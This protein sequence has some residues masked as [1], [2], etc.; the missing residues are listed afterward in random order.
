MESEEG[1]GTTMFFTIKKKALQRSVTI[2]ESDK[3]AFRQNA[4]TTDE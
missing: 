2:S 1:V 3:V 4:A